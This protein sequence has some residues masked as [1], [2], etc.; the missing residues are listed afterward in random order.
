MVLEMRRRCLLLCVL[1]A[2]LAATAVVTPVSAGTIASRS[3]ELRNAQQRDAALEQ[4][5]LR[6]V[7]R[8]RVTRGL[9]PLAL[10]ASLQAA[11]TFQSRDM[12]E[13]GYFDHDQPGGVSFSARLKRFYPLTSG[14]S[15]LVGENLLWS[16]AGIAPEAAV[17]LWLASPP[18]RRNLFDPTWREVGLG[19]YETPTPSGAFAA[20]GGPV[21]V[22]TMD[23]GSRVA[24][25][26]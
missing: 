8:L 14:A 19:A 11:A 4:G 17:K 21:V 26:R 2:L 15:W 10:S 12:L 1:V 25:K 7:N 6:E 3:S 20:A 18:H 22:V 13:R 24:A 23:F 9:R 16:S 5:I